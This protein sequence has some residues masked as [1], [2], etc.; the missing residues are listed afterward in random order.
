MSIPF[1]RWCARSCAHSR[2]LTGHRACLSI[3]LGSAAALSHATETPSFSSLLQQAQAKAPQLLEQAANVRA[4]GAEVRQAS[5][6]LN[7][8]LDISAENLGAPLAGGVSQR[9]DT[10]TVTLQLTD[11][12]AE[13]ATAGASGKLV[14]TKGARNGKAVLEAA[15]KNR[16]HAKNAKPPAGSKM[17]ATI[18]FADKTV[19]TGDVHAK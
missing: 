18:T 3:L 15:G 2:Y 8:T 13:V 4:A 14:W 16:M 12:G 11:Q 19:F 6:W 5:A 9:Q 1:L 7:P 17:Q 10:Y